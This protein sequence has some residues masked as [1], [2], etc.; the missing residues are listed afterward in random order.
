M[1][2]IAS[3]GV[4]EVTV[5][6]EDGSPH[7]PKTFV[8]WNPPLT[9]GQSLK[10]ALSPLSAVTAEGKFNLKNMSHT[11]GRVRARMNKCAPPCAPGRK[12]IRFLVGSE[13]ALCVARAV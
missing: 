4:P 9:M 8:L 12:L 10:G 2:T 5:V 7:G 1:H 13:L 6:S 3:A 11:E